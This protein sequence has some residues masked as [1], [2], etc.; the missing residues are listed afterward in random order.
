MRRLADLLLYVSAFGLVVMT[1]IISWQV[2]GRFVL[3]SSPSWSEQ[4]S[5]ILMIW[6]VFL[7]AAAGVRERFHIRITVLENI[8]S[9]RVAHAVKML[10]HVIVIACGLILLIWGAMLVWEVRGI[11]VP[12]L[13][14]SRGFAYLPIPVSGL[15]MSL[16]AAEHLL[17]E[18]HGRPITAVAPSDGVEIEETR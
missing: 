6:Y 13:G 8:A 2:F 12:A 9:P 17:R 4:A 5:L 10:V 7:A 1:A 14:I 15:L 3:N 18:W 16:F 11:T